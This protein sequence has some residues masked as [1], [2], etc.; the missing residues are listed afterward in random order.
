MFG[1]APID[2]GLAVS[3]LSPTYPAAA[4]P[5]TH[6]LQSTGYEPTAAFEVAEGGAERP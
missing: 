2:R 6:S 4:R 3:R 1:L 5:R